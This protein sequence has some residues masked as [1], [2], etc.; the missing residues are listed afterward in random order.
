MNTGVEETYEEQ[1]RS[2]EYLFFSFFVLLCVLRALRA[3]VVNFFS[4]SS[5]LLLFFFSSSFLF[6]LREYNTRYKIKTRINNGI[7][8]T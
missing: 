6:L 7:V 3:F 5:L 4:S 2:Q 8:N 1:V